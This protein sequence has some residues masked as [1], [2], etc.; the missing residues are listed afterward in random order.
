MSPERLYVLSQ[1][2]ERMQLE[3]QALRR[4][5]LAEVAMA[6]VAMAAEPTPR[7]QP[8]PSGYA[9]VKALF[10]GSDEVWK[11][12]EVCRAL[13]TDGLH[14]PLPT[15]RTHLSNLRKEGAITWVGRNQ[16]QR[17]PPVPRLREVSAS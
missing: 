17:T 13:A 16:Y 6:E 5:L 9:Q 10:E 1:C 8:H 4:E 11:A 7:A 15:V 3:I 14:V 12:E 2:L